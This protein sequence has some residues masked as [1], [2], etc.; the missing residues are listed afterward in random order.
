MTI[1]TQYP[2]VFNAIISRISVDMIKLKWDRLPHP[3][4]AKAVL[5]YLSFQS[6][7]K[8]SPFEFETLISNSLL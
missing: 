6:F 5:T 8:Q 3:F 4:T 1:G 7:Y 2:Q